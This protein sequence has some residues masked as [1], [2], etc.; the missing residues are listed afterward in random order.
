[1]SDTPVDREA[2]E[3]AA[4]GRIAFAFLGEPERRA[5]VA[6]LVREGM[7]HGGIADR[8]GTSPR[9]LQPYLP[10]RTPAEMDESEAAA[11]GRVYARSKGTCERCGAR[12]AESFSHR[13]P[14]GQGGTYRAANGLHTCG[15]GTSGC[16]GWIEANPTEARRH[17]WRLSQRKKPDREPALIYHDGALVRALLHDDGQVTVLRQLAVQNHRRVP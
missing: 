11:R 14:A 3:L 16:H 17:G 13:I 6:R 12:E 8:L 9:Q 10:R 15:D 5:V 4:A 7:S 2:V 1:V